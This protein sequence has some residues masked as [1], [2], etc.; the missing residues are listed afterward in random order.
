MMKSQ[1]TERFR[2]ACF[3][4]CPNQSILLKNYAKKD[5]RYINKTIKVEELIV[6]K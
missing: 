6:R 3:N 2:F 5:G 4:A 1:L